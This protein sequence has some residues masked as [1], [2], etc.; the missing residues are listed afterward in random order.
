MAMEGEPMT[1]EIEAL[2]NSD[3]QLQFGMDF[4]KHGFVI[5]YSMTIAKP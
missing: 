4:N 3:M 2:M 1:P 5:D